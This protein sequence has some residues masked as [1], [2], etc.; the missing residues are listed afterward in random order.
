MARPF[1]HLNKGVTTAPLFTYGVWMRCAMP[2]EVIGDSDNFQ[3]VCIDPV[4]P[5]TI[6]TA[7]GNNDGRNI[8][9]Y[10][11]RDYGNTWTLTNSTTMAGNPWGFSI[12]PDTS[13]DPATD[14][15]I[16]APA[17]YGSF[18]CWKSSDSA[19]TWTRQTG[20]DTAF[21]PVRP[22]GDTD[23]YHVQILPDD[24]P[25]HVLASFHYYFAASGVD[26]GFGETWDG[27]TTWA[28]H[29]PPT[30]VGTSHYI[31]PIS[32]TT[33]VVIAQSNNSTN[34]MWR[35]TTAGRTGGTAGA[36]YRDGTIDVAAWTQLS[37]GIEHSH[38]SYTAL[39]VGAN[40]YTP[41]LVNS[42]TGSIW[43]STDSGATWSDLQAGTYWASPP[44]AAFVGKNISGLC[45]TN[46]Y[47][48]GGYFL[49][50]QF[51]RAPVASETAWVRDYAPVPAALATF[52]PNP[53][54]SAATMHPSGHGILFYGTDNGLWRFVEP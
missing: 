39:N 15:V 25:N 12:N 11:S 7:C 47:L 5:G 42:S 41:G 9:W 27:G 23:L 3:S 31:L 22:F 48:Y 44:N 29:N 43:K 6:F 53:G 26:G 2:Q 32:G 45:A 33:W 51:A 20:C 46:K 40:W 37:E 24:P 10:R 14:P 49:G 4:N 35:T 30:N 54:G 18:G 1:F 36:K 38:G 28:I 13:R 52:G 17:G 50:P 34:G 19:V 21:T 8:K 16:Y